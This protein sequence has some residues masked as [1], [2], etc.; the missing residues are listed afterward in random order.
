M[1]FASF[2]ASIAFILSSSGARVP[3]LAYQ[4]AL[5]K[6]ESL[7]RGLPC[8]GVRI[9]SHS[10]WVGPSSELWPLQGSGSLCSLQGLGPGPCL[11]AL[12]DIL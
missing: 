12:Q 4:S 3:E 5:F 9:S 10:S 1:T 8:T 2:L 11:P 6:G 7:S